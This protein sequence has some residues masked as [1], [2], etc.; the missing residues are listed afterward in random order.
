MLP[1]ARAHTRFLAL[2][3]VDNEPIYEGCRA[4]TISNKLLLWLLASLTSLVSRCSHISQ[5]LQHFAARTGK[6]V[7][8]LQKAAELAEFEVERE[9]GARDMQLLTPTGGVRRRALLLAVDWCLHP[10]NALTMRLILCG[11]EP[12]RIC[13]LRTCQSCGGGGG[14]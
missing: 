3:K 12:S 10:A 8:Q 11:R 6:L 13:L 14:R 2:A 7:F 9:E 4:A 5:L 1:A